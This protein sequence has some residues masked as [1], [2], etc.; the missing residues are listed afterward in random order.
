MIDKGPNARSVK[1]NLPPFTLIGATTRSGLLTSPLHKQFKIVEHLNHYNTK[2]L[3]K[4]VLRATKI[5]GIEIDAKGCAEIARRS[6]GTPRVAN[7]I[8]RRVRDFAQVRAQGVITQ[9]VAE[10]GL[11]LL[12][13]DAFGLDDMDKRILQCLLNEFDGGPVGVSTLSIAVGEQAETLEEIYEPYLIQTGF[14][15]RTSSG[16]VATKSAYLHFGKKPPE[17]TQE[18]L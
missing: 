18:L 13:V 1:I 6:R 8:L 4:I 5:L 16:R 3:K 11:Q 10:E 2:N 14:M 17:R 12:E 15:K 7:R 9:K